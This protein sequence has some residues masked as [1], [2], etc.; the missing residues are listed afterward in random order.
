M[1]A[2][3]MRPTQ[4]SSIR[5]AAVRKPTILIADDEPRMRAAI[6]KRLT[7]YGYDVIESPDGLGVLRQCPGRA[8]DLI[9]LDH[10][11][12]NG[13]GQLI[14]RVL[15]RETDIP[16]VF[17]SGHDRD[18][19]RAIVRDLPDVYFLPKPFDAD[20]LRTLVESLLPPECR[21]AVLENS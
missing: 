20:K 1:C 21:Q 7:S 13:H 19:F 4:G 9:V 11:M 3:P 14:A 6:R 12:P 17:V 2:R 8:I 16:I 15:R 18:E 10:E 5:G